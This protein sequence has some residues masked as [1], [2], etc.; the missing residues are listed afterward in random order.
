MDEMQED[1]NFPE[2]IGENDDGQFAEGDASGASPGSRRT[3][4]PH[5]TCIPKKIFLHEDDHGYVSKLASNEDARA[6]VHESLRS[7]S[8]CM[9]RMA[10]LAIRLYGWVEQSDG[11][12]QS[13]DPAVNRLERERLK[14]RAAFE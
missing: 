2:S 7:N 6:S 5:R 11:L 9:G 1:E 14:Q 12:V 13:F 3:N 8:R 4:K 10:T